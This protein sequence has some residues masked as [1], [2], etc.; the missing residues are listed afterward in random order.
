MSHLFLSYSSQDAEYARWLE[1]ELTLNHYRVW[2]DKNELRA[3]DS[4][5]KMLQHALDEAWALLLLESVA[6]S[7]SGWVMNEVQYAKD[8]KI[9]IIPLLISGDHWFQNYSIQFIDVRHLPATVVP[10]TLYDALLQYAPLV[11]LEEELGLPKPNSAARMALIPSLEELARNQRSP[12]G[13]AAL[14]ILKNLASDSDSYVRGAA[15]TALTQLDIRFIESRNYS[16][17]NR[18]TDY[19]RGIE[20][21][22]ILL[23]TIFTPQQMETTKPSPHIVADAERR[24]ALAALLPRKQPIAR[25][26]AEHRTTGHSI[27]DDAG[28]IVLSD[29]AEIVNHHSRIALIGEPGSGKTTALR[30]I[31]L[32]LAQKALNAGGTQV[33][34]YALLGAFKG[35]LLDDFLQSQFGGLDL[36]EYYRS[37]RVF[38]LLDGLNET[39]REYIPLIVQWLNT[40]PQ[41]P[42]IVSC[43]RL[44]YLERRLDLQ[45]VDVLPLNIWQIWDFMANWGLDNDAREAL[46]WGLAG[47]TLENIWH[48]WRA[49]NDTFE[50]FWSASEI[51]EGDL[52]YGQLSGHEGDIYND[53]RQAMIQKNQLPGLLALA[54]NPFLLA[55]TISVYSVND[56]VPRNRSEM[57][58]QFIYG[59]IEQRG[60]LA[61]TPN[62]IWIDEGIQRIALAALATFLQAEIKQTYINRSAIQPI[63]HKA[64]PDANPQHIFDFAVSA[65]ILEYSSDTMLRFGHQ[66]IQ[67]YLA[68]YGM[69]ESIRNGIPASRYWPDNNWRQI[70]GWEET[71]ILLAGTAII[72]EQTQVEVDIWEV[73]DW[74]RPVQPDLAWRCM[75]E[76]ELDQ[77]HPV[78]QQLINPLPGERIPQ[79]VELNRVWSVPDK[80]RAGVG[81]T[82]DGLPDLVWCEI[83]AGRY[84]I[85]GD[86]GSW[87]AMPETEV[88]LPR[89]WMTKYPITYAQFQAFIDNPDGYQ[90]DDWWRDLGWRDKTPGRQQ[91]QIADCPR[92]N[93]NWYDAV[94]F[95]RWLSAKSGFQISLPTEEEWEVAARGIDGRI[96]AYG[97]II[98]PEITN[99]ASTGLNH[100]S[101]VGCF[102]EASSPF[103]LMDM[104]GNVWDWTISQYSPGIEGVELPSMIARG[105]S[106]I[107][108]D[109][110][111]RIGTRFD[112]RAT[113][114]ADDLGFRLV[115]HQFILRG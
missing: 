35:G 31:T 50:H 57:L 108:D 58:D 34:I 62:R 95:C 21:E 93:V 12:R 60:R 74:L 115:T 83:P 18:E 110:D 39:D 85:G 40:H 26:Y 25:T 38:V 97:N 10:D 52:A 24:N 87:Q 7:E 70:T 100:T 36:A 69:A 111:A 98:N 55:V 61:E 43:R 15:R 49:S 45:R 42:V 112:V 8:H 96:F 1:Q 53:M 71:A 4:W 47:D 28:K 79:T 113:R 17:T 80:Q 48:T 44:D 51:V 14:P 73:V 27:N 67:E 104:S 107:D 86:G 13:K 114:R 68:I 19:L 54:T 76:F 32:N 89:F 22:F 84:R 77:N 9:P 37:G 72:P 63:F 91:W 65:G 30:R 20:R 102:V 5:I 11:P 66:M 82:K 94:A 16:A 29:P 92:E 101:P 56:V 59:L 78:A 41:V 103:G 3:G 23:E 75:V 46:F 6:A 88:Q 2:R 81:Q 64:C 33:P 105:G 106:W 90:N 109:R 99:I